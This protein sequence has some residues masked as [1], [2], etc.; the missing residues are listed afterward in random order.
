VRARLEPPTLLARVQSHWAQAVGAAAAEQAEPISERD[1]VITVACRT[2][3]WSAE[4]SLLSQTLLEQLDES[5]GEG[6]RPR[7]LKFTVR[8]S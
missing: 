1:G 6:P 4:L 8:P 3:T 2:A 5:L 7:A